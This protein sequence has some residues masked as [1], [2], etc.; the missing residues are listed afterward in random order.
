[1]VDDLDAIPLGASSLGEGDNYSYSSI[2]G[3]W[4]AL[5]SN[6]FLIGGLHISFGSTYGYGLFEFFF[7]NWAV[8]YA[9]KSNSGVF[10]I[11]IDFGFFNT[12]KMAGFLVIA[13]GS[14][15][16]NF[17]YSPPGLSH[18]AYMSV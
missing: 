6:I 13:S 1:M 16:C 14:M 7:K 9:I 10:A 5:R 2:L 17:L 4:L 11:Q 18:Q 3:L 15:L 12:F 8:L